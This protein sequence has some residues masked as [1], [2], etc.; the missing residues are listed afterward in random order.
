MAFVL[1]RSLGSLLQRYLAR[2]CEN[3]IG[4][5]LRLS[6]WNGE[7]TLRNVLLR[8]DT[9]AALIGKALRKELRV[10]TAKVSKLHVV[11]PWTALTSQ[12]ARLELHDVVL[13]C[14]T[15]EPQDGG[16]DTS[17]Y[18]HKVHTSSEEE[19]SSSMLPRQLL[20]KIA[21]NL[22]VRLYNVRVKVNALQFR[23][24]ECSLSPAS[25]TSFAPSFCVPE[26]PFELAR[27]VIDLRGVS[28]KINGDTVVRKFDTQ[29]RLQSHLTD[30]AS[31]AQGE[32]YPL[33]SLLHAVV[34]HLELHVSLAH[35]R[36]VLSLLHSL[37]P[38]T[39]PPVDD[40]DV[41]DSTSGTE[42][43][44]TWFSVFDQLIAQDLKPSRSERRKAPSEWPRVTHVSVPSVTVSL[45]GAGGD[46]VLRVSA[47]SLRVLTRD[48]RLSRF[49]LGHLHVLEVTNASRHVPLLS[50]QPSVQLM[51]R[52]VH[53]VDD[54]TDTGTDTPDTTDTD[55]DIDTEK[56]E[57]KMT[58]APAPSLFPVQSVPVPVAV[59][60]TR[61]RDSSLTVIAVA[62]LG[63]VLPVAAQSRS[64]WLELAREW[65]LQLRSASQPRGTVA[66]TTGDS[67]DHTERRQLQITVAHADVAAHVVD[68]DSFEY[69][70]GYSGKGTVSL[71]VRRL[72]LRHQR[73]EQQRL[74]KLRCHVATVSNPPVQLSASTED[75]PLHVWQ[76]VRRPPTRR[77]RSS[78][79]LARAP[80][81][82]CR[83]TDLMVSHFSQSPSFNTAHSPRSPRSPRPTS[84]RSRGY[85]GDHSSDSTSDHSVHKWQL[86]LASAQLT[87]APAVA[88][89]SVVCAA[90]FG[91]HEVLP[92]RV[93][94]VAPSLGSLPPCARAGDHVTVGVGALAVK[95]HVARALDYDSKDMLLSRALH[96][97]GVLR[98]LQVHAHVRRLLHVPHCRV[99][100]CLGHTVSIDPSLK[101]RVSLTVKQPIQ[102]ALDAHSLLGVA[103]V[104]S[105]VRILARAL[106]RAL[107]RAQSGSAELARGSAT[108][109]A[110]SDSTRSDDSLPWQRAVWHSSVAVS[111]PVTHVTLVQ[112][113]DG[114]NTCTWSLP[115]VSVASDQESPELRVTT[116]GDALECDVTVA[117]VPHK[118]IL[119]GTVARGALT[120]THAAVVA[121]TELMSVL[122]R[123]SRP[124]DSAASDGPRLRVITDVTVRRFQVTLEPPLESRGGLSEGEPGRVSIEST[125]TT[126]TR[127]SLRRLSSV[128]LGS[129]TVQHV[130]TDG[131]ATVT[132]VLAT[133]LTVWSLDSSGTASLQCA[134]PLRVCVWPSLLTSLV[135]LLRPLGRRASDH[136]STDHVPSERRFL[137]VSLGEVSIVARARPQ[138]T[139]SVVS[140]HWRRLAHSRGR[141]LLQQCQLRINDQPCFESSVTLALA[142]DGSETVMDRVVVRATLTQLTTLLALTH[143]LTRDLARARGHVTHRRTHTDTVAVTESETE[144][145]TVCVPGVSLHLDQ[146]HLQL[147]HVTVSPSHT[148]LQ[149]A[150]ATCDQ[151]TVLRLGVADLESAT[152]PLG[153]TSSGESRELLTLTSEAP[154]LTVSA[155]DRRINATVLHVALTPHVLSQLR[156]TVRALRFDRQSDVASAKASESNRERNWT[157]SVDELSCHLGRSEEVRIALANFEIEVASK[158][159]RLEC[160]S[161]KLSQTSELLSL[162]RVVLSEDRRDLSERVITA[163]CDT[164]SCDAVTLKQRWLGIRNCLNNPDES[165]SASAES[166]AKSDESRS[167]S[168]DECTQD[169]LM[170]HQ[171]HV[172][173][174]T[175]SASG[176]QWHYSHPR[177]VT[178]CD[179]PHAARL[180][181][182]DEHSDRWRRFNHARRHI[183]AKRFRLEV[184]REAISKHGEIT[185]KQSEIT[186]K[187]SETTSKQSET[188]SKQ[189]GIT[190]KQSE[191]TSRQSDIILKQSETS[192]DRGKSLS[193]PSLS[194]Q[195][196]RIDSR[197]SAQTQVAVALTVAT[198]R[199]RVHESLPHV[200]LAHVNSRLRTWSSD[201]AETTGGMCARVSSRSV[202][203][204][205][206]SVIGARDVTV[207]AARASESHGEHVPVE[208]QSASDA[209]TLD[210]QLAHL[211]TTL[212]DASMQRKWL[213]PTALTLRN[214]SDGCV[215]LECRSVDDVETVTSV[216]VSAR[217]EAQV[218]LSSALLSLR[219][220]AATSRTPW[221]RYA[222]GQI[223]C[224]SSGHTDCDPV[225]DG[226]IDGDRTDLTD[227][228][229]D[230]TDRTDG[231]AG[232]LARVLRQ[233][234]AHTAGDV[235]RLVPRVR[236]T[237]CS[238][239]QVLRHVAP[240]VTITDTDGD[241]EVLSHVM[242]SLR[243]PFTATPSPLIAESSVTV[244]HVTRHTCLQLRNELPVAVCVAARTVAPGDSIDWLHT[245]DLDDATE[246]DGATDVVTDGVSLVIN[247]SVTQ[248]PSLMRV[249]TL[250]IDVVCLTL[251]L[252]SMHTDGA[253]ETDRD[254]DQ[255]DHNGDR[256]GDRSDHN[257][258]TGTDTCVYLR[259]QRQA[260]LARL[261][262]PLLVSADD[263]CRSWLRT[264]TLRDSTPLPLVDDMLC[265]LRRPDCVR[266]GDF[267]LELPH[268]AHVAESTQ[269]P[270]TATLTEE[271]PVL[272]PVHASRTISSTGVVLCTDRYRQHVHLRAAVVC[273]NAL[274]DAV[275]V[276]NE[277][278]AVTPLS[279][280][281]A[282]VTEPAAWLTNLSLRVKCDDTEVQA[283]ATLTVDAHVPVLVLPRK[284]SV[285][286]VQTWSHGGQLH[287]AVRRVSAPVL[288]R[289]RLGA[290]HVLSHASLI[291]VSHVAVPKHSSPTVM[292]STP[293]TPC[294]SRV[295]SLTALRELGLLE[296]C[297]CQ[298]RLQSAAFHVQ[299][300]LEVSVT[301]SDSV[302]PSAGSSE[303]L[304]T[305]VTAIISDDRPEWRGDTVT[306]RLVR[307]GIT[308]VID[309]TPTP[310]A[311]PVSS[312]RRKPST[313]ASVTVRQWR[314]DLGQIDLRHRASLR[315]VLSLHVS[316]LCARVD[317]SG[318]DLSTSRVQLDD[319]CL[320]RLSSAQA[321]VFHSR[322]LQLTV[323]RDTCTETVTTDTDTCD[324]ESD[325]ASRL[326]HVRHVA[327]RVAPFV[328][329]VRAHWLRQVQHVLQAGVITAS[330]TVA[331]C[332]TDTTANTSVEAARAVPVPPQIVEAAAANGACEDPRVV[333][334]CVVVAPLSGT[335]SVH[336][337]RFHWANATRLPVRTRPLQCRRLVGV[338]ALL[339]RRLAASLSTDALRHSP[340]MIASLDILGNPAA[341]ARGVQRSVQ[342]RSLRHVGEGVLQSLAALSAS[343]ART[344]DVLD[345]SGALDASEDTTVGQRVAQ[346][347]HSL[348]SGVT[349]VV[350]RPVAAAR[351][352]SG[353]WGVLR[354]LGMGLVGA[355]AMPLR[356]SLDLISTAS[357]AAASTV[358]G[359]D[360]D[361][362]GDSVAVERIALPNMLRSL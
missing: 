270:R 50:L 200:E 63:A 174:V 346:L 280:V 315:H 154:A 356:A 171:A 263:A 127:D 78:L 151:V 59:T 325:G 172:L 160:A 360:T 210:A 90:A 239:R 40:G 88:H 221:F 247:D 223:V 298:A 275:V 13:H 304:V 341:M 269:C 76:V 120:V 187:Q 25:D 302:A 353:S 178:R 230:H 214:E 165:E 201:L 227:G 111:L 80:D 56:T 97:D 265:L 3:D 329:D 190:S 240:R 332:A 8:R 37:K 93:V 110:R 104:T 345:S 209:W 237:D 297:T 58:T 64:Q 32:V 235:M 136:V 198:A 21:A 244:W 34:P 250:P 164:A 272:Q 72:Q 102:V 225:T 282:C 69:D 323:L 243:W 358:H 137:E 162:E 133:A 168:Q 145:W 30:E 96:C 290:G 322:S 359:R 159:M 300:H 293:I 196:V 208:L 205:D 123:A 289:N 184:L 203:L 41:L 23:I 108:G 286:T 141:L 71:S 336:L 128:R 351:S 16:L 219:L 2:L 311:S 320:T 338:P 335:V 163:T 252:L 4:E 249:A 103:R 60:V 131:E 328:A 299:L 340:H 115:T 354:G 295:L 44:R 152:P 157:V 36:T 62:A 73:L 61:A 321:V 130:R 324:P 180:F 362:R 253:T 146:W 5:S 222:P 256:N 233:L 20:R 132:P 170:G 266:F 119:K 166:V 257:G 291:P 238:L 143:D 179:A 55:T 260:A 176:I 116:S 182:F 306:V 121:L 204:G 220:A 158:A 296:L 292:W 276:L 197:R 175:R 347:P 153:D 207:S 106:T 281:N 344:L 87:L 206:G 248:L 273:W 234:V 161:A 189:S 334:D 330:G 9:I 288:L 202:V 144:K 271:T 213:A 284:P 318:L 236:T 349:G 343:L 199:V 29:L 94:P 156:R 254:G 309:V 28:L 6:L 308:R 14:K 15:K 216:T 125:D 348:V 314:C 232:R 48:S 114:S 361:E 147:R 283:V 82:W 181:V 245:A 285:V 113:N 264:V 22:Q 122:P 169:D 81:H 100:A 126:I 49:S 117:T 70:D 352:G 191:I 27:R 86:Q 274:D 57:I 134:R 267:L 303:L 193:S 211:Q 101:P 46:T 294:Q 229:S 109:S 105:H 31:S 148:C 167:K 242:A 51:R 251:P 255:G 259:L 317:R 246:C 183:Y 262:A 47:E 118:L 177:A 135:R 149:S 316:D 279:S 83:V 19:Q 228:E 129:L 39:R 52:H 10:E 339:L 79:Q 138:H 357:S 92:L 53:V 327:L 124:A 192:E 84:D 38:A 142:R 185:S 11:L 91:C 319:M 331:D 307:R 77:R 155:T 342:A 277:S 268:V 350:T 231:V 241:Q 24:D 218:P 12:S 67:S 54:S 195:H 305:H 26:G 333:V 107:S 139:D 1:Q 150:V 42:Q 99:S 301:P 75:S 194:L 68:Y 17:D 45:V 224:F 43:D 140:L 337:S 312:T 261:Q 35:V 215:R 326:G 212:S 313:Q 188:T 355:V 65:S 310:A 186:L 98:Q 18:L 66:V 258:V 217:S 226:V 173:S 89:V 74:L 85:S 7:A 287:V 278:V 112:C 95:W 33:Q